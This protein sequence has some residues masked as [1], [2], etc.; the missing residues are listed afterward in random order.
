[1]V[2]PRAAD[3]GNLNA[4][5]RLGEL[6]GQQQMLIRDEQ[7]NLKPDAQRGREMMR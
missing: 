1:V 2:Q 7:G 3:A 6:M 5:F 4:G